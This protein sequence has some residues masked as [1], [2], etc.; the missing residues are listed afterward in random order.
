MH[1]KGNHLY[2]EDDLD[3]E[4]PM[5]NVLGK[6]SQDTLPEITIHSAAPRIFCRDKTSPMILRT[7]GPLSLS[8]RSLYSTAG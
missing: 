8:N 5:I 1:R 4:V 2:D 6:W 3:Y 7:H